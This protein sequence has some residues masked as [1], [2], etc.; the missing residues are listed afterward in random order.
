MHGHLNVKSD[1]S[2]SNFHFGSLLYIRFSIL[3]DS[4]NKRYTLEAGIFVSAFSLPN[5]WPKQ[6]G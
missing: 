5:I 3:S 2:F 1:F 4:H 6:D